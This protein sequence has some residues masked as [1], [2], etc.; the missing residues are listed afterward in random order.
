[1][2]A[3]GRARPELARRG[4]ADVFEAGA[5]TA[6]YLIVNADDFGRSPGINRGIVE[7]HE[8]GIVTSASLMVRWP[9]AVQ[10]A[11][12]VR[13]HPPL[14]LGLH[15]DLAEWAVTDDAWTPVYEVLQLE[16]ELAVQ[17]E[18]ERQLLAFRELV[19]REPSH[20]DSHHHVHRH[21]PLA[22]IL[23]TLAAELEVP[24][25]DFSAEVRYSGDFYGQ[26]GKGD[27]LPEAISVENLL[28]TLHSLAPGATEFGCHPGYADDVETTY[29]EERELEVR[30]LCD[31]R[32]PAALEAEGIELRTFASFRRA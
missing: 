28:A 17:S 9:A 1:M 32:L 27:P 6:R 31:P 7:A 4:G 23:R 20:L 24:L 22:G 13:K 14:G 2:D 26:G 21:E 19:G 18:V 12:Y 8:R 15:V 3:A 5:L 30:T 11:E 10:A 16:D 25:R 29:R